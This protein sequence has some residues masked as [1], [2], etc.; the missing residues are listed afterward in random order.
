MIETGQPSSFIQRK[1][2]LVL[3]IA[4]WCPSPLGRRCKTKPADVEVHSF[5]LMLELLVVNRTSETLQN[6][7]IELSTQALQ[8]SCIFSRLVLAVLLPCLSGRLEDCG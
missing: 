6:V 1:H 8:G 4:A 5:D 7:L 2:S 3:E